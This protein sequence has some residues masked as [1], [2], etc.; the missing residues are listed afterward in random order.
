MSFAF[1]PF[2]CKLLLWFDS[3]PSGHPRRRG[4][5]KGG[6]PPRNRKI[7]VLLLGLAAC[8]ILQHVKGPTRCLHRPETR[9]V[10]DRQSSLKAPCMGPGSRCTCW[11][12]FYCVASLVNEEGRGLAV[13][14]IFEGGKGAQKCCPSVTT[15]GP[16]EGRSHGPGPAAPHPPPILRSRNSAPVPFRNITVHKSSGCTKAATIS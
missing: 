10:S 15:W 12:S 6:W 2:P 9:A 5:G 3:I 13:W 1:S 11:Y 14:R 4:R 7:G 16:G 8:G